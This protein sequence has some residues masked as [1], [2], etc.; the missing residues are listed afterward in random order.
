MSK[1]DMKKNAGFYQ[2][3][4]G[5]DVSDKGLDFNGQTNGSSQRSGT[6]NKYNH[7]QW[8]GHLNDGRDVQ[9]AQMP[10]RKGNIEKHEQRRVPPAT[11]GASANPVMSGARK[12]E[13][14]A[15]MN[16]NGNPDR[17]QDR[18]MYNKTGNKD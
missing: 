3:R 6:G 5:M 4:N 2:A 15:G 18:Q 13:P 12:W 10:N 14:S 1:N 9:F 16:F 17:I 11:A 7:N 8:S